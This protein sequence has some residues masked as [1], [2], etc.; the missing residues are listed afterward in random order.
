[1]RDRTVEILI[2]AKEEPNPAFVARARGM[3]ADC[4]N[5]ELRL[6]DYLAQAAKD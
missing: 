2:D 6:N 5:F 4:D 1:V 3:V